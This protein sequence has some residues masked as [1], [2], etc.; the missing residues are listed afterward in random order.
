MD[1]DTT[2]EEWCE[3][4]G[5]IDDL[6]ARLKVLSKDRIHLEKRILE[7]SEETELTKF[8][9]DAVTVSVNNDALRAKYNPETWPEIIKWA[10][11]TSN[12]HIIQRRLTDAKVVELFNAGTEFP[13]GL[14]LEQ[15]A[16]LSIR[17]K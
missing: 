2:L 10:V 14:S 8:G 9:N 1:I 17:R 7:Y 6:N 13:D 15:Y 11:E 4:R 16:K 3:V 12:D 5:A